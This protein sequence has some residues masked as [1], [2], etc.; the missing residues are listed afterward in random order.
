MIVGEMLI[1][2]EK[3]QGLPKYDKQ[4]K[5]SYTQITER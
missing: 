2:L 1:A 3:T 5:I 4:T